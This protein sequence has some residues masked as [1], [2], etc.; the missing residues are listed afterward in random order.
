[1]YPKNEYSLIT[2]QQ[3]VQNNS[4]HMQMK[5]TNILPYIVYSFRN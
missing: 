3:N 4:D 2:R 5:I 1:M